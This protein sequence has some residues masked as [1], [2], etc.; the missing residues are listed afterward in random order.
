MAVIAIGRNS[1]R[2]ADELKGQRL[3]NSPR[4][5]AIPCHSFRSNPS[6]HR[7]VTCWGKWEQISKVRKRVRSKVDIHSIS[8]DTT[9]LVTN[10]EL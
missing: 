8:T 7:G 3:N 5:H 6:L 10:I 1:P 2:L 9:A 4:M